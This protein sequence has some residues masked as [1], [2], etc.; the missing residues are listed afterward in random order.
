MWNSGRLPSISASVSPRSRPSLRE[1]AGER[2][3]ALAQLA[4]GDRE[5]VALGADRDL[6]GAVGAAVMRNA[7]AIV[8]APSA[9]AACAAESVDCRL[10]CC[11]SRISSVSPPLPAVAAGR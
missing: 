10:H 9:A 8:L 4:P 1:P 3:D 2:V 7:S 11:S 5:R 6:I